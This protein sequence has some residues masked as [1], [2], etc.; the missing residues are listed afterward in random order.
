V[1]TVFRDG[2][3]WR[4]GT[5]SDVEW[6]ELLTEVG[7]SITS[8]IPPIF[9]DYATIVIPGHEENAQPGHD[10]AL[11]RA[12]KSQPSDDL[13]WLGY[14]DRGGSD[15]VFP[16]APKVTMYAGWPYV[17]VQA[18]PEQ[19]ATWRQSYENVMAPYRLPDLIFPADRSWFI[20]TLWDDDWTCVGGSASLIDALLDDP[21]LAPWTRRVGLS[22]DATPPGHQSI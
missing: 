20:S 18:E 3:S 11:L 21:D 7:V 2:R 13:W 4:V 15:T 6:I 10:Q 17:L 19:A 8:A 22:E 9:A 5:A 14:L 16:E 12:L 1:G